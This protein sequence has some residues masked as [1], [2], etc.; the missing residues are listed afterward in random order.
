MTSGKRA[1]LIVTVSAALGTLP[2]IFEPVIAAGLDVSACAGPVCPGNPQCLVGLSAAC[3]ILPPPS[4]DRLQR[5]MPPNIPVP[6][7]M[8]P[9]TPTPT[10]APTSTPSETPVP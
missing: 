8:S 3:P 5:P 2:I 1:L 4:S 10:P 7:N 9:P 6:Q